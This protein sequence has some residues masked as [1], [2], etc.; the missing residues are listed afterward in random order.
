MISIKDEIKRLAK[1]K[2]L[3]MT[4]VIRATGRSSTMVYQVLNGEEASQPIRDAIVGLLGPDAAKAFK[5]QAR[6]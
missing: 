6:G 1:R 2:G 5:R 4:Q 3:N